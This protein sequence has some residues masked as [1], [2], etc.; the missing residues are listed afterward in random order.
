MV[1][2]KENGQSENGPADTSDTGLTVDSNLPAELL[3]AIEQLPE[4]KIAV[5]IKAASFSF[6]GPVP[7]PGMLRVYDEVVPGLG[8]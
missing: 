4:E 1:D 6:S 8:D 3:E 5:V 7:P 2:E